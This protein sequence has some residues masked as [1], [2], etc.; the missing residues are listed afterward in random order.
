MMVLMAMIDND[1][2]DCDHV[3]DKEYEQTK[4][5]DYET[6]DDTGQTLMGFRTK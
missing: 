4:Y 3:D 6:S 1:D 2:E 5:K